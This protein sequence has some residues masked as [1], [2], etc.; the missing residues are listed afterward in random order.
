MDDLDEY[1]TGN[2]EGRLSEE[3]LELYQEIIGDSLS[4]DMINEWA[5]KPENK[6]EIE[7]YAKLSFTAAT[8]FRSKLAVYLIKNPSVLNK[9]ML[10]KLPTENFATVHSSS[11][12]KE[13]M[14]NAMYEYGLAKPPADSEL[15]K[16]E[17][18]MK[19]RKLLKIN[20]KEYKNE[21]GAGEYELI[22]KDPYHLKL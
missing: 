12:N 10:E 15:K 8:Q 14:I 20:Y 6:K 21:E 9:E 18:S 11:L 5:E 1:L 16:Y 17:K 3:E 22:S 4:E 2:D 7:R 19:D 13:K